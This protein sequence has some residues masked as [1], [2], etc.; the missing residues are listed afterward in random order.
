VQ[1]SYI[2]EAERI[3]VDWLYEEIGKMLNGLINHLERENRKHRRPT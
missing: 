2:T 3:P 1:R